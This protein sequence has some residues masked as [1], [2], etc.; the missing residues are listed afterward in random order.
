MDWLT[1]ISKFIDSLF[2]LIAKLSWPA[3]IFG[4]AYF[5]REKIFNLL[6]SLRTIKYDKFQAEFELGSSEVVHKAEE[7]LP[8]PDKSQDHYQILKAQLMDSP[9]LTS[10]ITAWNYI[11]LAIRNALERSQIEFKRNSYTPTFNMNTLLEYNLITK[12]QF[13]LFVS[14]RNL[15]NQAVNNGLWEIPPTALENYIDS[16]LNLLTFLETIHPKL[17]NR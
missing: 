16:A 14:M 9:P 5:G 3:V 7:L 11:D 13:N 12:E 6:G 2:T 10:V 8:E 15:R 17:D 1:F 4:I